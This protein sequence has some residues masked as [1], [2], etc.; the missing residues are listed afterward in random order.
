LDWEFEDGPF[1]KHSLITVYHPSDPIYGNKFANVGIMGFLGSLSGFNE[2][3][4]GI[5]EIGVSY[6]ETLPEEA[7][8]FGEES[9]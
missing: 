7:P 8:S 6:P 3:Q 2:Y 4:M 1:A 5:S 9:R